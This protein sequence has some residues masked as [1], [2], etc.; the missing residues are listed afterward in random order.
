MEAEVTRR[1]EERERERAE[2][3]ERRAREDQAPVAQ[4]R[5]SPKRESLPS[6]VLTPLLKR[7]RDLGDE[8][9]NRLQELEKKLCVSFLCY[10][11]DVMIN[12]SHVLLSLQ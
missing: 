4:R 12:L 8:L 3:E 11:W 6:G 7:N 5:R 10:L 9:K 1:L 2:E